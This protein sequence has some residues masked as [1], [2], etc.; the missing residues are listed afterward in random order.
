MQLKDVMGASQ[1][2]CDLS[3]GAMLRETAIKP[4]DVAGARSP[5]PTGSRTWWGWCVSSNVKRWRNAAMAMRWT[6][7]GMMGAANSRA[8]PNYVTAHRHGRP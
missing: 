6:A 7:A 8:M 5:A 3:A 1:K 4:A 2:L